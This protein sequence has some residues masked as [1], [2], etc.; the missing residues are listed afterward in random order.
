M[1]HE[2]QYIFLRI[3]LVIDMLLSM[4]ALVAAYYLRTALAYTYSSV[5]ALFPAWFPE[6]VPYEESH[7]FIEYIWL[8]PICAILWPLVLNR[9]GYYDLYDLR[10][11]ITRRWMII[12]ASLFSTVFLVLFIFVFKQQ[13]I[14]RIVVVGTGFCAALF[15]MG[16]E[17]LPRKKLYTSPLNIPLLFLLST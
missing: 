4:A 9:V 5:P 14:A 10:Q 11:P 7:L 15:L 3:N 16:K 13:F 2:R 6:I 12:K 17:I 1:V 8:F